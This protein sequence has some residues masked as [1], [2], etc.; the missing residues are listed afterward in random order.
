MKNL[1]WYLIAFFTVNISCFAQLKNNQKKVST[2]LTASKNYFRNAKIKFIKEDFKG[3]IVDYTH[4]I[5][6]K[7]KDSELYF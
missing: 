5:A 4:A 3:A 1:K 2:N 7:P 6:L